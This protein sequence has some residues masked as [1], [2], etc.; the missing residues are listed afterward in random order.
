MLDTYGHPVHS[1]PMPDKTIADVLDK[2]IDKLS[3]GAAEIAK[4]VK[5]VAP[6]AW[7]VAV[8]QQVVEGALGLATGLAIAALGAYAA[9][10]IWRAAPALKREKQ[11][12]EKRRWSF[13]SGKEPEDIDVDLEMFPIWLA[14]CVALLVALLG[15]IRVSA[16]APMVVNPE[17]YAAQAILEAV[18]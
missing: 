1:R 7:E 18:K 16:Y 4:A 11:L 10:R 12:L 8:R 13:N 3:G 9:V 5:Q 17:Y 2:S 14:L 6:H 15:S